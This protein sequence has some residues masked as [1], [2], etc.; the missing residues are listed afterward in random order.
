MRDCVG[1]LQIRSHISWKMC[2]LFI[3]HA[4]TNP[5]PHLK[6]RGLEAKFFPTRGGDFLVLFV[7]IPTYSPP[8][9]DLGWVGLDIDRCITVVVLVC[10]LP[11]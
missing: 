11:L 2:K 9:P 5:L 6:C 8:L 1:F 7:Q 4:I 10:L 3:V